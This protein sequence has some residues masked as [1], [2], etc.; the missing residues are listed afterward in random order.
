MRYYLNSVA[1]EKQSSQVA[2]DFSP[3]ALPIVQLIVGISYDCRN[4][5]RISKAGGSVVVLPFAE[6]NKE[7]VW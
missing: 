5:L 7:T 2:A 4:T 6:R 3:K 1:I